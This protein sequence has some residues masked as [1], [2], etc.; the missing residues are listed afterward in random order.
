MQPLSQILEE[1]LA[2]YELKEPL[3]RYR[4]LVIWPEVV[5]ERIA[6]VTKP[7][8]IQ[9]GV[10]LVKVK[11]AVWR[12]ELTLMKQQIIDRLNESLGKPVVKDIKF[13]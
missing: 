10:L 7:V 3:E 9:N 5:G 8:N 13:R 12:M 2:H 4:S 6:K 11:S 1:L